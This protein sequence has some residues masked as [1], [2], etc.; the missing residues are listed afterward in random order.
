MIMQFGALPYRFVRGE[1][2]V[3]LVTSRRTGRWVVPKGHPIRG[4]SPPASA[5]REA[6]EEAGVE[7]V[8]TPRAIGAY[9]Y[10]KR[11]FLGLWRRARVTVFPLRVEKLLET[12]P[13]ASQRQ[14]RW[15]VPDEAA[16]VVQP[17]VLRD[18]ILGFSPPG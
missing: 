3:L 4:L 16:S 11:L 8:V 7:G 14:R 18:L 13:E 12:W 9:P 1:L 5:A 15:F 6:L 2:S 17:S 10:R